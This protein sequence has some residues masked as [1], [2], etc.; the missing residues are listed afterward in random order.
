MPRLG[1]GYIAVR[2]M[3]QALGPRKNPACP[4]KKRN[5]DAQAAGEGERRTASHPALPR[6]GATPDAR[7]PPVLDQQARQA[8]CHAVR[9]YQRPHHPSSPADIRPSISVVD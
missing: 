2:L 7:G 5:L 1:I 6:N 3:P 8:S 9:P 4:A